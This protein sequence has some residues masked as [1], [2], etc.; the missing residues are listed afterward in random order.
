ME[1]LFKILGLTGINVVEVDGEVI[2]GMLLARA[3]TTVLSDISNANEIA[4]DAFFIVKKNPELAKRFN[5]DA[6][7][8]ARMIRNLYNLRINML[9]NI[10]PPREDMPEEL[11]E[12]G[13]NIISR[14]RE[15]RDDFC[16]RAGI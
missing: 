10:I 4:E 14:V 8:L 13:R 1:D 6:D 15:M 7:S 9:T 2:R 3:L 11:K 16:R 5:I 12:E